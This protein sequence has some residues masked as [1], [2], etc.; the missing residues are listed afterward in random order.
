MKYIK[1]LLSLYITIVLFS[2]CQKTIDSNQ[3]P[4]ELAVLENL[5]NS[6]RSATSTMDPIYNNYVVLRFSQVANTINR[7]TAYTID[8]FAN[9]SNTDVGPVTINN[10]INMLADVNNNNLYSHHF[11]VADG[12]SLF[13]TSIPLDAS[14]P[15]GGSGPAA[16]GRTVM[17]VPGQIFPMSINAPKTIVD[18]TVN[19]PITWAPDPN[20]QFGKVQIDV[21][22]YSSLSKNED[23][24]M[25]NA[26]ASLS[27][28]VTDNGNYSI[29]AAALDRF[30]RG[31]YIGISVTRVWSITSANN[32]A[33]VSFVEGKTI[34]LL[35]VGYSP[36][37]ASILGFGTQLG[38]T[39]TASVTGG[40]SPISYQWQKSTDNVNWSSVF[41]TQPSVVVGPCLRNGVNG[42]RLRLKATDSQG[43][44]SIANRSVTF[45]C[46]R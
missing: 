40:V 10:N 15:S 12:I 22:Y 13:G 36:L 28:Q 20:N 42:Y 1:L 29:P 25:P 2:S 16:R 35:V 26:V 38:Q 31:S 8:A 30:P 33:Y 17:I 24:N 39:L 3:L 23:V 4:K 44:I 46:Y 45:M 14:E 6:A 18:R 41:S 7:N 5:R 32:V 27:Y 34:P 11:S 19:F 9:F 43:T 37:T 21:Y